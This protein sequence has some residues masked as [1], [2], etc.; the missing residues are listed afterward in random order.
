MYYGWIQSQETNKKIKLKGKNSSRQENV[1][2]NFGYHRC[3]EVP[4]TIL[5]PVR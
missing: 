3:G 1:C 2:T 4:L 5:R